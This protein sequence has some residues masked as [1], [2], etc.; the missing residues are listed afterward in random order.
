VPGARY[1]GVTS[2]DIID[3]RLEDATP[4][5]CKTDIKRARDALENDPFFA[6]QPHWTAVIDQLLA[7]GTRAEQQALAK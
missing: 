3:Y 6:S 7:M 1:L 4:P 5:P 2:Q